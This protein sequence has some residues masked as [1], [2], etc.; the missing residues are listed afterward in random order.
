MLPK[1]ETGYNI[2][3]KIDILTGHQFYAIEH[4]TYKKRK[5]G[6]KYMGSTPIYIEKKGPSI[7]IHRIPQN[8]SPEFLAKLEKLE[9]NGTYNTGVTKIPLFNEGN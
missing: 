9:Y 6:C 4:K 2:Y 5:R 8:M 3:R 7:S 1:R